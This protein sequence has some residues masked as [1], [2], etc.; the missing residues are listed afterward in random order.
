MNFITS[1][2][3]KE[4]E[5]NNEQKTNKTTTKKP[6]NDSYENDFKINDNDSFIDKSS[7]LRKDI[8]DLNLC[9][10]NQLKK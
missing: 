9:L 8:Q 5:I 3:R 1:N 7:K 4:E 6:H 10:F 2:K